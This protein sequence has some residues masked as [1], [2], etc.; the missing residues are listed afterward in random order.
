MDFNEMIQDIVNWI[1]GYLADN[2]EQ[3]RVFINSVTDRR[4]S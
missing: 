2:R 3:W 4:V 1:T